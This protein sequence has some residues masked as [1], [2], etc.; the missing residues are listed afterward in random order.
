VLETDGAEEDNRV[1][2]PEKFDIPAVSSG[3]FVPHGN[4]QIDTKA[5][6]ALHEIMETSSILYY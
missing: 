3:V 6:S 1:A 2:I 5:V 4:F